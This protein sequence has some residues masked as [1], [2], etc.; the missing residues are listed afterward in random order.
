V[1]NQNLEIGTQVLCKVLG[2]R[3]HDLGNNQLCPFF[4]IFGSIPRGFIG[5]VG[6]IN[7][8]KMDF[9]VF[10]KMGV[11][12]SGDGFGSNDRIFKIQNMGGAAPTFQDQGLSIGE[13]VCCR[14]GVFRDGIQIYNSLKILDFFW[15]NL[16]ELYYYLCS[17][18]LLQRRLQPREEAFCTERLHGF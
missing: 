1:K 7:H 16:P 18:S 4:A 3:S 17:S 14:T 5:A 9:G 6:G 15:N 13:R 12:K 11:E 2:K 10:G 8:D